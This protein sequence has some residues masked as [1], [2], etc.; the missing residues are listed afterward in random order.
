MAA[1][2]TGPFARCRGRS[3]PGTR[4][5]GSGTGWPRGRVAVPGRAGWMMRAGT[6]CWAAVV[7]LPDGQGMVVT[8]RI[9]LAAQPWLADHVVHG[10]V[11]LPGAAFAELAWHAGMLA[12]C[13]VIEDLT[14]LVPLVLPAS[15]GVQVQVLVGAADE[16]GRRSLTVSAR[17]AG[18]AGS[19][20]GTPRERCAA[21]DRFAGQRRPAG[22]GRRPGRYRCRWPTV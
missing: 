3:C 18:R 12:G 13:P 9:S 22:H 19:G 4:S 2:L 6:R 1:V 17:V 11:I 5:S 16:A 14:L 21:R 20:C 10:T 15:G 8:G 7:E